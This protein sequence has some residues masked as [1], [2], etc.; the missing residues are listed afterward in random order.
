MPT[1]ITLSQLQLAIAN[2]PTDTPVARRED[3]NA[4]SMHGR[5]IRPLDSIRA[6]G[7]LDAASLAQLMWDHH[8]D[9][10]IIW[11]YE[12][13]I[14]WYASVNRQWHVPAADYSVT[15]TRHQRLVLDIL[16]GSGHV[17]H[18]TTLGWTLRAA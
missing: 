6:T 3:F 15:T 5:L 8:D 1:N 18:L 7:R 16:H 14:A 4:G 2:D 13:P 11:S 9:L 17:S 10:F 12:T